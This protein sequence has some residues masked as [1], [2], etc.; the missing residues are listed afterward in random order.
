MVNTEIVT[1]LMDWNGDVAGLLSGT[2]HRQDGTPFTEAENQLLRRA[3]FAEL[4]AVG[5]YYQAALE[6][7]TDRQRDF[8]RLGEL[9]EPAF[10]GLP[11]NSRVKDALAVMPDADRREALEIFD[12]L[13]PDG[14]IPVKRNGS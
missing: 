1:L 13:A 5:T 12:R 4:E 6:F 8:T 3:G 11:R 14:T 7:H 9:L 10:A 2:A